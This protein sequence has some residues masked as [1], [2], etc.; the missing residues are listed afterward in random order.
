MIFVERGP[1]GPL[2]KLILNPQDTAIALSSPAI[3]A[4]RLTTGVN[5]WVALLQEHHLLQ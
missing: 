2:V 1:I 5:Q 3:V 4:H